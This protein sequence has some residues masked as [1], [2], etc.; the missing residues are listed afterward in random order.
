MGKRG[1]S[2][3]SPTRLHRQPSLDPKPWLFIPPLAHVSLLQLNS[4]SKLKSN[5][6]TSISRVIV[7]PGLSRTLPTLLSFRLQHGSLRCRFDHDVRSRRRLCLRSVSIGCT[8]HQSSS[9][10]SS[11]HQDCSHCGSHHHHSASD[12]RRSCPDNLDLRT[13]FISDNLGL[14]SHLCPDNLD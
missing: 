13:S 1:C 9:R 2:R 10:G 5:Q 3:S 12:R 6:I 7:C 8:H 11:H 14:S 4:N